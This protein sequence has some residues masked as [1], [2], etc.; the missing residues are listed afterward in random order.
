MGEPRDL[1]LSAPQQDLKAGSKALVRAYGG[2]VAAAALLERA[3]S[4]YSDAGSANTATFLT[5]D[6]VA[7][8]E[9]RTVG[10]AGHPLVTTVLARRQGFVLAPEPEALPTGADLVPCIER[11]TK[12]FGEAASAACRAA[13]TG[14][15]SAADLRRAESEFDDLIREAVTIRAAI[16]QAL[17]EVTG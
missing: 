14:G 2:Q 11:L 6:E 7:E 4:R 1:Q 3:Q 15:S 9:D 12:E 8:L 13:V 17:A 5:I 16:R 10:M